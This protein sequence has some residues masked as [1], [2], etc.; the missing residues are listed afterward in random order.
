MN[1]PF[2]T[3]SRTESAR[4][5]LTV[6]IVVACALRAVTAGPVV[7]QSPR[8]TAVTASMSASEID[9]RP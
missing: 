2:R 1:A 7:S 3:Q 9:C 8:R 4:P 5:V 6:L